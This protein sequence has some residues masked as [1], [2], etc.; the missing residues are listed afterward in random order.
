[1][2]KCHRGLLGAE[3]LLSTP[4]TASNPLPS[5]SE[6][7]M[8]AFSVCQAEGTGTDGSSGSFLVGQRHLVAER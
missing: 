7:G 1:M 6:Q 3:P 8:D 5:H 2:I 4:Y